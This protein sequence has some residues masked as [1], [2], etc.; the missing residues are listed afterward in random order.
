MIPPETIDRVREAA[1]IAQIIGEHVSLR[2]T[3]Q[4]YR[5]PCPFHQG[6]HRNFSVSPKK[7]I[8]YCFVCHESGDVFTFVQKRLGLDWPAAVRMIADKVG[9][10]VRETDARANAPDDREPLWEVNAAAAE[11]FRA[12]LW[13][14]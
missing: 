14:G 7:G 8:Y 1:D 13:G 4:D 6:K 3:G 9:I 10:E 11:F 12:Q 2:K 5:G